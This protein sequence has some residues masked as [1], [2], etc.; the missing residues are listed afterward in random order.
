MIL[1]DIQPYKFVTVREF[2][3]KFQSFHIGQKLGDEFGVH[4]DKSKSHHAAL[5]TRSYGV[6][7]KELLK[8]CSAREFLLMKSLS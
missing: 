8:A 6:S 7:K 2:C 4:F 3:E 5:T 1:T